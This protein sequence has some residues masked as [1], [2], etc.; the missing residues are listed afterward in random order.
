MVSVDALFVEAFIVFITWAI[1]INR[2]PFID[3][4]NNSANKQL[5]VFM[6]KIPDDTGV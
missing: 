4:T 3:T 5:S 6:L 1:S 2:F